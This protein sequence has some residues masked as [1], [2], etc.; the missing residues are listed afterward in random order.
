MQAV[1]QRVQ[2]REPCRHSDH[3]AVTVGDRLDLGERLTHDLVEWQVVLAGAPLGNFVHLGLGTIDGV[4]DITGTRVAHRHDPCSGFHEAP[5]N[6]L[7]TNDA[8]VVVGVGRRGNQGDEGVQVTGAADPRD[9]TTLGEFGRDRDRIRGFAA[10]IQLQDG[11][12]DRLVRRSVEVRVTN[13]FNNVGYRVFAQQHRPE[14][15]LFGGRVIGW[16]PVRLP[17]LLIGEGELRNAHL[18]TPSSAPHTIIM[19]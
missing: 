11:G 12:V 2:I 16:G 17:R 5:E 19:R 4:V 7:L 1:G 14:D 13:K 6:R 10:A 9:F 15:R 3:F 18:C 8:P